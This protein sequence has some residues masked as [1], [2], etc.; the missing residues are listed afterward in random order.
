[1]L[2]CV[3]SIRLMLVMLL[4]TI[5]VIHVHYLTYF[6]PALMLEVYSVDAFLNVLL[7]ISGV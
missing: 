5:P 4:S 7:I 6:F 2:Q 1:M 3:Y